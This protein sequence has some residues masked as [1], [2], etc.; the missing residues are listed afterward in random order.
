MKIFMIHNPRSGILHEHIRVNLLLMRLK[1]KFNVD[2]I[3]I[4]KSDNIVDVVRGSGDHYDLIIACGGD[5]TVNKVIKGLL[6]IDENRPALLIFPLGSCN[7]FA[8]HYGYTKSVSKTLKAIDK[9]QFCDTDVG[10]VNNRVFVNVVAGGCVSEVPHNVPQ[11]VK[12]V[13]G[14]LAYYFWGAYE[15]ISLDNINSESQFIINGECINT[16]VAL[17]LVQNSSRVGGFRINSDTTE[18]DPS[19][20]LTYFEQMDVRDCIHIISQLFWGRGIKHPKVK[21]YSIYELI[22][23]S[24]ELIRADIDGE[25]YTNLPLK[26]TSSKEKIRM[27]KMIGGMS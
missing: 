6:E 24:K 5:G 15:M 13:L 26:V 11:N 14:R 25:I 18:I 1:E 10:M 16:K 19:L 8:K 2:Y 17:F 12:R 7:D 21:T 20:K 22:I 27:M 9:A 23:E 3:S 4:K